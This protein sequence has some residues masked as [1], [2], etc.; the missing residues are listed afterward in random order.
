MMS[1]PTLPHVAV[2]I[3]IKFHYKNSQ[4]HMNKLMRFLKTDFLLGFYKDMMIYFIIDY[5][6]LSDLTTVTHFAWS[7]AKQLECACMR[8]RLKY[9]KRAVF[10][11][12]IKQKTC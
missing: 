7:P 8:Y 3:N 9:A 6:T 2:F 12:S 11:S 5:I 10:F 1:F 4:T